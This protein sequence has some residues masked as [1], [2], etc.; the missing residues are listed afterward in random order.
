ME[1]ITKEMLSD[2]PKGFSV[3]LP[4]KFHNFLKAKAALDGKS[5]DEYF[6]DLLLAGLKAKKIAVEI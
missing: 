5:K 6:K 1:Q 4:E 3:R 2:E